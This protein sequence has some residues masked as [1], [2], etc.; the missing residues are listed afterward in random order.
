MSAEMQVAKQVHTEFFQA[1]NEQW[2]KDWLKK[3]K[4]LEKLG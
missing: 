4:Q 3:S 1:Q 2:D